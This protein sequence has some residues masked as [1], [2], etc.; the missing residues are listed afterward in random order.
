MS[1][2]FRQEAIDAQREK[3]LGEATIARP[4]PAWV[5]TLLAAGTA[6][7]LIAVALWGQYTRRERVEGFLALDSG[8]A[9]VTAPDA[10]RIADLLIHEGDEVK[11]GDPMARVSFERTIASGASSSAAVAAEMQNR[12][13]IL[14][15]EQSQ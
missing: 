2:L 13:H 9:R 6:V 10:G 11:S 12:R 5:F 15:K 1:Q 4:V 7:L 3:F 14:E 8:A